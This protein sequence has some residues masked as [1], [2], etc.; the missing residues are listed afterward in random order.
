MTP[1]QMIKQMR[2]LL[3]QATWSVSP[4]EKIV[5]DSV[6]VTSGPPAGEDDLPVRM[7]FALLNLGGSRS[8]PNDPDL[9]EQEFVLVIAAAVHGDPLGQN[10]VLGGPGASSGRYGKSDGRGLVELESGLLAVLGRLTGADG[11]Q[12]IAYE[13]GSPAP[14][15]VDGENIVWR[16]YTLRGVCTRQEEYLG[17]VNLTVDLSTPGQAALSWDLPPE[18]YSRRRIVCRRASGATAPADQDSGASVALSGDLATSVTVTGLSAG[19]HSFAL[20][21][22]HTESGAAT[23]EKWSAQVVGSYRTGVVT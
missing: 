2:Y 3:Q 8:D 21:C 22:A 19:S 16:R 15:R 12:V 11:C 18:V 7:P 4:N 9:L 10:A 20:F 14:E 17:P 13:D 23:D 5:G 6:Y 1:G